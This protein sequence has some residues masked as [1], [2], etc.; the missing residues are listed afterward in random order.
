MAGHEL[1]LT[2]NDGE[3]CIRP[4]EQ[5]R[6]YPPPYRAEDKVTRFLLSGAETAELFRLDEVFFTNWY[7]YQDEVVLKGRPFDVVQVMAVSGADL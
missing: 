5:H 1:L 6:L 2:P 3:I 7:R 4:W